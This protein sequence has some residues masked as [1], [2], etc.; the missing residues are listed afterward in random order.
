MKAYMINR[1][2]KLSI[3]E[4]SANAICMYINLNPRNTSLKHES[5]FQLREMDT[6]KSIYE[7]F[8]KEQE[9]VSKVILNI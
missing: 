7:D 2:Q 3:V 8:I 9:L 5:Y 1:L 4:G 6:I